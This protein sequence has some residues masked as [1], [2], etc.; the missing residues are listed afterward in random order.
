V[1][2]EKSLGFLGVPCVLAKETARCSEPF[3][4]GEKELLGLLLFLLADANLEVRR[5]GFLE[6]FMIVAPY[7]VRQV[8][9]HV[10]I[11][12]EDGH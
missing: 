5:L 6:R 11:L 7:G 10:R 4:V 2:N 12:G 1:N 3:P 8:F 9:I